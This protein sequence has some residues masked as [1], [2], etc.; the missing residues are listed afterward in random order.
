MAYTTRSTQVAGYVVTASD[1]NE[2]VNNDLAGPGE[3]F[4][5]DGEVWIATGANAGEAVAILQASNF[6]KHEYGGLEFDAN[7][8]TTGDTV[9]GQSAGVMGLETAMS[10]AQAE[11]GTDTQVRGVTAERIKQ[12]I[13]AQATATKNWKLYMFGGS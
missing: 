7:A 8:V 13:A 6:L 9:V 12:A 3:A 5:N 4:A 11:A 2:S 10:Q 1:W